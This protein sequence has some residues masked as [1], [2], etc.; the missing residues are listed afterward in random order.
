MSKLTTFKVTLEVRNY[1]SIG[2]FSQKAM[3]ICA[4]DSQDATRKAIEH[5]N[6]MELETRFVLSVIEHPEEVCYTHHYN[7]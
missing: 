3:L 2:I 7:D 5:A 1:N 4:N 6:M